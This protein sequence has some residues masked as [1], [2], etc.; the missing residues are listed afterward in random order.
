M[1]IRYHEVAI[2]NFRLSTYTRKLGTEKHYHK[3]NQI[4]F[5]DNHGSNCLVNQ[6][7]VARQPDYCKKVP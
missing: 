4:R 2:R 3:G 1:Y 7:T 5:V 6:T